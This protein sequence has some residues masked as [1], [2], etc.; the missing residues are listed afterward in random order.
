MDIGS[1]IAIVVPAVGAVT[2]LDRRFGRIVTRIVRMETRQLAVDAGQQQVRQDLADLGTEFRQRMAVL[3]DNHLAHLAADISGMRADLAGVRS[4]VRALDAR[5][6]AL[7]GR[8]DGL[9]TRK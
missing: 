1:V 5:V 7:E 6:E 9:N 3:T 4:D 8:F 2:W